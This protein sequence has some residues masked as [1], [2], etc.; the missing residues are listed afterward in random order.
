[1]LLAVDICLE[2]DEC[3]QIEYFYK[4]INKYIVSSKYSRYHYLIRKLAGNNE[5]IKEDLLLL[6]VLE[7]KLLPTSK[8]ER[9]I[10]EVIKKFDDFLVTK[11]II[12]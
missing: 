8:S 2:E 10:I 4:D 5:E 7:N 6:S 3:R 12:T 11:G 9:K 1:M